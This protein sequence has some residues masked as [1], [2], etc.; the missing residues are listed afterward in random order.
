LIQALRKQAPA[1]RGTI[2]LNAKF[3][4]LIDGGF[5]TKALSV[6]HKK[7]PTPADIDAECTRVRSHPDLAAIDL[8]RIYFYDA[9][10]ASE[11]LTNPIDGATLD[12]TKTP[13]HVRNTQLLNDLELLPNF[14]VRRGEAMA[15]G[16]KIG[17]A[18]MQRLL[19]KPATP[20]AKDLVPNIS[21]KGVDLRIGLDIARIALRQTAQVICVI[22][23]DSDLIPAFKFARREGLRVYLDYLGMPIRRELRAHADVVI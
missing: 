19:K 9:P 23:G 14:A 3:A 7:F 11:I 12:L 13:I 6:K 16:W 20:T 10:P 18:A 5:L 2:S 15:R 4:L 17:K 22:T 8:M 21:Q 1:V